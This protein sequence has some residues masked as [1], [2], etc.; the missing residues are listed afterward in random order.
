M[1][2]AHVVLAQLTKAR[3][4][5][6]E[7][8]RMKFTL[9]RPREMDILRSQKDGLYTVGLAFVQDNCTG[10]DGVT[11]GDIL[12][13]GSTEL[14]PFDSVV[15]RAWIA[16]RPDVFDVMLDRIGQELKKTRERRDALAKN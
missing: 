11:Y 7:V 15:Y 1:I 2:E 12:G 5:T 3:E 4:F 13:D 6:V 10:W 16:D 14:A 8:G 9:L